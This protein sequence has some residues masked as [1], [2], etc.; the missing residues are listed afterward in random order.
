[1]TTTESII[2]RDRELHYRIQYPE[3]QFSFVVYNG[4]VI[5]TD[6]FHMWMVGKEAQP[7]LQRFYDSEAIVRIL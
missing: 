3:R 1:M 4:T 2:N 7:I 5:R 6:P